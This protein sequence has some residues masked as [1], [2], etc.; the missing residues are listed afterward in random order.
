MKINAYLSFAGDCEDALEYYQSVLGGEIT[1][2][3]T[4]AG[5][6]MADHVGEDWQSKIMH[7]SLQ[8][9]QMDLMGCDVAPDRYEKPQGCHLSINVNSA[10]D[11]DRIF[12][13]LAEGGQIV[14]PIDKTFWSERFGMVTDRFGQ[15][16]MV[17]CDAES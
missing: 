1:M 17:N 16:W 4:Y 14:M 2:M 12:A 5:S 15:N 8:T 11:A 6:P 10:A 3:E 9:G 13:A 7:G